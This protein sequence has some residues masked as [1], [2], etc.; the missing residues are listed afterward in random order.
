MQTALVHS[1]EQNHVESVQHFI[2]CEE[3]PTLDFEAAV[4]IRALRCWDTLG[5]HKD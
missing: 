4:T 2:C 3:G 1:R 5:I